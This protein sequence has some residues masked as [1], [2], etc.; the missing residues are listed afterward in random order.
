M[1]KLFPKE[2]HSHLPLIK[3]FNSQRLQS[4]PSPRQ[5]LHLAL[6]KHSAS[7]QLQPQLS[8]Q[9]LRLQPSLQ[10][11]QPQPSLQQLLHL[12]LKKLTASQ[13][14]KHLPLITHS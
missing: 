8:L 2:Q 4:H 13:L 11:L 7:Q 3:H 10:Q 12:P 14:Q 9:Q 5:L 6:I 1:Y